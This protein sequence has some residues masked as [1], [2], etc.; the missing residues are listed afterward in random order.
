[1]SVDPDVV[2]VAV[3]L[4]LTTLITWMFYRSSGR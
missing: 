4:G 1:M 3:I 2:W